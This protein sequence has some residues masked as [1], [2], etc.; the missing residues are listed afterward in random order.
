MSLEM[1][2]ILGRK[3]GMSQVFEEGGACV[4]VTLIEAGP[5]IVLKSYPKNNL[6]KVQLGFDEL[7][8][9]A[10]KNRLKKP[11][12]G[13]FAKVNVSPKKFIKEVSL[14]AE[15]APAV[16]SQVT[17]EIFKKGDYVD[18]SG[19]SI[20]KGFQGGMKRWHWSG[21]SRTHGSTSKRR[22]GSIGA[23]ASPS[24]VFKRQHMPGHMGCR[25]MTVQSLKVAGVQKEENLLI[26]RGAVMG[27]KDSYLVIKKSIKRSPK[28]TGETPGAKEQ[29][30]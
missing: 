27:H 26:V 25:N 14:D 7:P 21:G 22:V 20:G 28:P 9:E 18:I 3:I 2:A 8:K 30:K 29:S 23:S 19:V 1:Q 11:Q 16:G 5:C 17:V 15:K 10:R 4:A 6:Q 24:R 12:L 13:Y